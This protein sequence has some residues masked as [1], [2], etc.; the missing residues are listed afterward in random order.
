MG[1]YLI[2]DY[3][4]QINENGMFSSIGFFWGEFY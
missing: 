2:K 1:N 4:F 3:F